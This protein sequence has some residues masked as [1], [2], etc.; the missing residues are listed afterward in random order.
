MPNLIIAITGATGALTAKILVN[1]SPW[2]VTLIY[3]KW[4]G[5]VYE[6]ECEPVANLSAL[7]KQTFSNDDLSASISSGSVP[8]MGMVIAPCSANT[9]GQIASGISST[10]ITRAAHCHLKEGRKLILCLREAPLSLIDIEN[11]AKVARAGGIIMPLSPPF[12]MGKGKSADKITMV[13]LLEAYADRVLSLLGHRAE[14]NW[15]NM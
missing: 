15:E 7:A 6:K 14:K 13:E 11:S 2:P 3:S 10:L 8:T 4:G 5:H 9:L 1:K 12:Y